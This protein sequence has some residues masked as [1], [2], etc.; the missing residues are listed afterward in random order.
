LDP[1]PLTLN[2]WTEY[3]THFVQLNAASLVQVHVI[4]R[5]IRNPACPSVSV[6]PAQLMESRNFFVH[7][8]VPS[9]LIY[10]TYH[11]PRFPPLSLFVNFFLSS[12][13]ALWWG[14]DSPLP[15]KLMTILWRVYSIRHS[16]LIR[17][18]LCL[19]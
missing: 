7:P 16:K 11:N 9:C 5:P 14:R 17:T 8:R 13:S 1:S 4:P 19:Q 15:W 6:D 18:L 12:S 10:E 2:S 3:V